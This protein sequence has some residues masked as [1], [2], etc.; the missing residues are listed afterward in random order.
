MSSV[1]ITG[2]TVYPVKE[3]QLADTGLAHHR[4]WVVVC[5]TG[6]FLTQRRPRRRVHPGDVRLRP[7]KACTRCAITTTDQST[8]ARGVEPLLTLAGYRHDARL[9]GVAFGQNAIIAAGV[10]SR[11]TVGDESAVIWNF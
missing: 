8:G 5:E 3:A 7:V 2:L 9:D 10:R 4:E 1:R 6:R 11:L